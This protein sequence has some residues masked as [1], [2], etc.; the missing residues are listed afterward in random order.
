M[1]WDWAYNIAQQLL[2]RGLMQ[3]GI[4]LILGASDTGKTTLTMSLAKRLACRQPIGIVD[5]DIGQSH[6]GP[7]TTVGWTVVDKPEADFSKLTADGISFVG[8]VTPV[9]HL[10]Q[11]TAAIVQGVQQVSK[12]TE[13]IIIDTPGLIKGPAAAALWWNVQRILNPDL[14]LAVQ[15]YDELSDILTGLPVACCQLEHVKAPQQVPVKSPTE[16]QRYRQSQFR[17]Y[18]RDCC[19]YNIDLNEVAIQTARY[20]SREDMLS[21]IVG[22]RNEKST[23]VAIGVV[24]DWPLIDRQD[25]KAIAVIRAPQIDI[26]QIRCLILGDITIDI[27]GQ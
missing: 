18:F 4:C 5:A 27:A 22:L 13:L 23:D 7:P 16:R 11:L 6:I 8:H 26:R 12:V 1:S 10:L 15:R 19:L 3:K 9:G 20:L 24:E 25:S 14:L 2:S 17:E 21:R